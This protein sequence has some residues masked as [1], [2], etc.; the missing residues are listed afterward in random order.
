MV[1]ASCAAASWL[2]VPRVGLMGAPM[3]LAIGATVQT[4][5]ELIIL[6]R[7]FRPAETVS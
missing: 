4:A 3:A 6:G 7:A 2:L 1:A 5:G